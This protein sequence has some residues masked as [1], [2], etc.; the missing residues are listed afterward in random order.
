MFH[1]KPEKVNKFE[2]CDNLWKQ[3]I[4]H[5][6]VQKLKARLENNL[7]SVCAL[8]MQII[9]REGINLYQNTKVFLEDLDNIIEDFKTV[10]LRL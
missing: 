9:I 6:P 8:C 10:R 7:H 1:F 2:Y 3:N 4:F 5:N